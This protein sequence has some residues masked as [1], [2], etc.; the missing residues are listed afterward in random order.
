M[1]RRTVYGLILFSLV[2]APSQR[3]ARAAGVAGGIRAVT[4]PSADITLSFVQP[5]RIVFLPFQEGDR[6]EVDQVLIRQDDA[7]E[8][9]LLAQ[10]KAQ[11]DD[12]TQ[13]RAAEASLAQ[14]RVDL[15]KLEKAAAS[16][17]ATTLEVEHARL[18]VTI[19]ELSL[20]LARFEHEQAI[21]KYQEQETRIKQMQLRSPIDGR[22]EKIEIEIGESVNALADAVR[23]VKTDP[24]WIDAPVPLQDGIR[25]K[26]GATA[27]IQI[28]GANPDPETLEGRVIFVSSVADAA[29]GT[30]RVRIEAPNPSGRPAGEHVLVSF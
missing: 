4:R 9:I 23:V 27:R 25:L 21:R 29:S 16:N 13:I 10:L 26:P 8:Q 1:S 30:L 20:Q 28:M 19:A 5:G 11:A 6:V 3:P 15:A 18:D 24:L 2:M 12:T 14:K 17:A 22:I 7:A